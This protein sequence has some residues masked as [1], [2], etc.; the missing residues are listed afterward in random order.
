MPIANQRGHRKGKVAAP[1]HGF[2]RI[3]IGMLSYGD[4]DRLAALKD[5]MREQE[6]MGW[7]RIVEMDDEVCII[8]YTNAKIARVLGGQHAH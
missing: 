3:R 1:S 4:P 6:A 7:H 5:L 8:E 2:E